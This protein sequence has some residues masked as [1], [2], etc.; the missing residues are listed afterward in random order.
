EP[1]VGEG[2]LG[3]G[4]RRIVDDRRLLAAAAVHMAVECVV[5]GIAHAAGE[6][7]AIDAGVRVEGRL[8]LFEPVEFVCRL[9]PKAFRIALP[10]CVHVVIAARP[11]VHGVSPTRYGPGY[12]ARTVE[13]IV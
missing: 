5:A 11:G 10:A 6:P 4:E 13:R 3:A 1:V 8:R 2:A 7:A 12:I 9:R